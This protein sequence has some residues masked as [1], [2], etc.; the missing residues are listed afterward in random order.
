M[1]AFER[2]SM[3]V[4]AMPNLQPCGQKAARNRLCA[5]CGNSSKHCRSEECERKL[6]ERL[7]N[8]HIDCA[9]RDRFGIMRISVLVLLNQD[10]RLTDRP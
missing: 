10:L 1:S 8:A 2:H 6:V 7:A 3:G 9:F 5:S 4:L